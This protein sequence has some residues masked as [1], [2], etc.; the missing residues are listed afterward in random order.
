M[1]YF[2]CVYIC[3][4]SFSPFLYS[5]N[6]NKVFPGCLLQS[7]FL[8]AEMLKHV[9]YGYGRIFSWLDQFFSFVVGEGAIGM[10]IFCRIFFIFGLFCSFSSG[11]PVKMMVACWFIVC[12]MDGCLFWNSLFFSLSL[13]LQRQPSTFLLEVKKKKKKETFWSFC[14]SS[15][16]FCCCSYLT[17]LT[18][19]VQT[20]FF[21]VFCVTTCF[22]VCLFLSLCFLHPSCIS[23]LFFYLFFLFSSSCL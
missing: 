6:S 15:H 14:K 20:H 19:Y 22:F 7:F 8:T 9:V 4:D 3:V 12:F 10:D 16:H 17:L 23:L 1:G 18:E 11:L 5:T 13:S 2:V 21:F